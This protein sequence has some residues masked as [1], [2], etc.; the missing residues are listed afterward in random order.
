MVATPSLFYW[1]D[2]M[3]KNFVLENLSNESLDAILSL[4]I[5]KKASYF[6]GMI[7][8]F[9]PKIEEDIPEFDDL[10][11]TYASSFYVEK[12]YRSNRF[13]NEK[14]TP[15][16]TSTGLIRNIIAD[17]YYTDDDLITH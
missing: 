17:M 9:Y 1:K 6:T 3:N 8:S 15:I 7:K 4:P 14:F 11:A 5:E 16:Y 10:L 13:F 12:I 2:D